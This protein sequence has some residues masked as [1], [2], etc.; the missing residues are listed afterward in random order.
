MTGLGPSV[1]SF[2]LFNTFIMDQAYGLDSR[3]GVIAVLAD[4]PI[5]VNS[6]IMINNRNKPHND[7]IG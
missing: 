1:Y 6:C 7:E 5:V 4:R 3:Y 2:Y